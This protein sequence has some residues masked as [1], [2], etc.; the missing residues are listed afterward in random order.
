MFELEEAK[1]E[2]KKLKG[3]NNY[4]KKRLKEIKNLHYRNNLLKKE[5]Q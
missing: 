1:T 2:I 4:L 3:E 5:M